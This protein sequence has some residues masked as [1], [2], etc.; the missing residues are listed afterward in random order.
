[1]LNDIN[2]EICRLKKRQIKSTNIFTFKIDLLIVLIH[3]FSL[4]NSKKCIDKRMTERE[5]KGM[6]SLADK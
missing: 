3:F 6:A 2:N 4:V 1:M 5:T